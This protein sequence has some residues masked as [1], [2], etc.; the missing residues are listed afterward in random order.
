MEDKVIAEFAKSMRGRSEA[1]VKSVYKSL[2]NDPQRSADGTRKMQ[3]IVE[4]Y[5]S[6]IPVQRPK[7]V[8]TVVKVSEDV[9]EVEKPHQVLVAE[10]YVHLFKSAKRRGKDFDL[11]LRDVHNLMKQKQCFYTGEAFTEGGD[12]SRTIDRIDCDKGY[13]KGNVVACTHLANQMKAQ[14]FERPTRDLKV[15]VDFT[16]RVANAVLAAMGVQV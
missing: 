16:A 4:T 14:L 2:A 13:V 3:W 6:L 8:E 12:L 1:G 15:N 7:P 9:P 10:K 5:P 11:E